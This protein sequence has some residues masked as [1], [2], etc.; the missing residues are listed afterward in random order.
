[1]E[2]GV[3]EMTIGIGAIGPNAGL[4]VW[5]ALNRVER[6]ASGAVGGFATFAL[7]DR[8]N[9]VHYYH[10]QRGGSSTLFVYG[11][12]VLPGP[13]LHVASAVAAVVISGGPDPR[14]PLTAY[15]A[16]QDGVGL[17]T[18]H[19]ITSAVT[20]EGVP[21]N[22]R[23]L[24]LMGEGLPAGKAVVRV[25]KENPSADGGLIALDVYGNAGMANSDRVD[26]RPDSAKAAMKK[27]KC[28][29]FVLN[30]RIVPA[31]VAADVAAAT[32]MEV[33]W[34]GR[35][36][37]LQITISAGL[38]A[39]YDVQD[40]V[41]IDESNEAVAIYTSDRGALTG[42]T[43]AAVP[44]LGSLVV[45]QDGQAAGRLLQEFIGR[46]K[47]GT[48]LELSGRDRVLADVGKL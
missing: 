47:D 41:I 39:Q 35:Q 24:Q 42:E 3:I 2:K 12:A 37:V 15:V 31:Q 23:V 36:P 18:G 28:K 22:R 38:T 45:R 20:E 32:A 7:L 8:C 25:M 21:L 10:T 4:A 30:N 9:K 16:A 46:L 48:I 29:V 27:G 11:D 5:K 19:R 1:M 26:R 33:M 34:R 17:V 44:Y 14:G 6:I 40:K 43:D 13:P